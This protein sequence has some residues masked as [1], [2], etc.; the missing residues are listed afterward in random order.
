[1]N[2]EVDLFREYCLTNKRTN[3]ALGTP[4]TT[5]QIAEFESKYSVHLTDDIREFFLK[6]N[7]ASEPYGFFGIENLDEWCR[8]PEYEFYGPG[9]DQ[10]L[11]LPPQAYFLIGHYDII[12][13][14][15]LIQLYPDPLKPTPI[16]VTHTYSAV[17]AENFSDFLRI[18]RL[19]EPEALHGL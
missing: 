6:I 14:H 8:L 12:V 18:W 9:W 17:V 15:W 11:P 16:T 5:E 10:F 7:G 3:Y 1:M 13:W 2:S 4:A 19:N